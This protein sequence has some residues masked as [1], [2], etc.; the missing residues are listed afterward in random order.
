M[1][2][3]SE[4]DYLKQPVKITYKF[5]IP[6]YAVVTDNEVIATPFLANGFYTFAMRHLYYDTRLETR[7]YPFT[8]RC[9]RYVAITET[10]KV[11]SGYTRVSTPQSQQFVTPAISFKGGKAHVDNTLCVGCGVCEQLCKFDAFKSTGKEA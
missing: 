2:Y 6:D 10:L 3:T 5:E 1:K 4:D 8:D 9:S 7:D 11:P